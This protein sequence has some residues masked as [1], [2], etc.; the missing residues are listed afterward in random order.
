M[1]YGNK[2][3]HI[4]VSYS[5]KNEKQVTEIVTKLR[6]SGLEIWQDISGKRSGIPY[7]T[8]WFRVIEE[9]IFTASGAIIFNTEE[10]ECSE[11]CLREYEVIQR[12][13]IPFMYASIHGTDIQKTVNEAASWC[14]DQI[15]SQENVYCVWMRSGAYRMYKGLPAK[16]YFPTGR[17]NS[18]KTWKWIRRCYKIFSE[19][20]F[21]GDW[22]ESLSLFL[23][24]AKQKLLVDII[25][26][27]F[28]LLFLASVK[29]LVNAVK[30]FSEMER[31]FGNSTSVES[32]IIN[33]VDR[34]KEYDPI[35]AAQL[36]KEYR[37]AA[38]E[39]V[40]DVRDYGNEKKAY[41]DQGDVL[42]ELV[43]QDY[44][45]QN[46]ILL[47]I[48]SKNYPV[49]F[50]ESLSMCPENLDD[51]EENREND[52]FMITLSEDTAQIF[53]YDKKENTT[54]QLL[55]AAVPE[56]YC[57]SE[58]G[59]ELIIA[60]A[61]KVYIYNLYGAV[62]PNLLSYNYEN[63]RKIFMYSNKIYAVTERE[64]VIV[65]DNPLL[66]RKINDNK[67]SSGQIVQLQDGHIMAI[68]V[69]DNCLIIN[70]D[71]EEKCYQLSLNGVID[72]ENIAVSSD[73][74]FAAISYKPE[75]EED[76][77]IAVFELSTGLL[78]KEYDT[79][80]NIVGFTFVKDKNFIVATRYD[81]KK[82]QYIDLETGEIQESAEETF[83]RPYT[84][85]EYENE[86]LVCDILGMLTIYDTKL[87]RI[88][89]YRI[90]GREVPLK[91]FVVSKKYD[92]V[93]IAGRGG[94]MPSG[95]Y[96]T[97]LSSDEQSLFMAV[98]E[99]KMIS[100]TAVATDNTGEYVAFGNAGG[101]IYLWDLGSMFQ[102]WNTH[103]IPDAIVKMLFSDD[104]SRLYVLGASGTVYEINIADV[105]PHNASAQAKELSDM[106][107][108]QANEIAKNMY[109]FGLS[110]EE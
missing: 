97:W 15:L 59:N 60:A 106:Y 41:N 108:E 91:Q 90:I 66:E 49:A 63:I 40:N 83:A 2:M 6:G 69:K 20:N 23:K 72:K 50:Y 88:G 25:V 29:P 45:K 37:L 100:T 73:H 24:K 87:N 57:F 65:W 55:L 80:G 34:I 109:K 98:E 14:R 107:M 13:D 82:I 75:G 48:V 58:N 96:V 68:Y 22:V 105:L 102:I 62:P 104:L 35:L 64:H 92:C 8:K 52:R 110:M 16:V 4:F 89:D 79:K 28:L 53:I 103:S 42:A 93:L 9:A 47:D 51:I 74:A 77:R 85:I 84:I 26:G 30:E 61:N 31:Y 12:T 70:N 71:N 81:K 33:K 5:R 99:E 39:Y 27:F 21:Q 86:F 7:S 18:F 32:A 11:P 95:N 38:D 78:V 36:L 94:N 56:T 46:T 67:I 54:R 10:W 3:S 17:V 1:R 76:D 19:K 43:S 101:S 44:Y